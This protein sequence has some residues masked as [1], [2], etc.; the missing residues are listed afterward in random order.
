MTQ[1]DDSTMAASE[2]ASAPF[3]EV[4]KDKPQ[5]KKNVVERTYNDMICITFPSPCAKTKFNPLK[6]MVKYDSSITVISPTEAKQIVLA[7]DAILTNEEEF[8]KFFM[9]LTNYVCNW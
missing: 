1:N 9:V 4:C 3:K 8:K 5:N 2:A 6:E 7:T